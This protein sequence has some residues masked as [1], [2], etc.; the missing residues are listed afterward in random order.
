MIFR[1]AG[2]GS[3]AEDMEG[4]EVI[5]PKDNT[6]ATAVK[7]GRIDKTIDIEG[8]RNRRRRK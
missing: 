8:T 4:D 1:L 7:T 2:D 6:I 5:A 3:W